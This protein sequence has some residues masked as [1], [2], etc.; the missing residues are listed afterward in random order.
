[1]KTISKLLIPLGISILFTFLFYEQSPGVNTLIFTLVSMFTIHLL[2]PSVSIRRKLVA[3]VAPLY[4]S[5][6]LCL[7]VQDFTFLLWLGSYTI[8]WLL[9]AI[10]MDLITAPFYSLSSIVTAPFKLLATLFQ[11]LNTNPGIK[12]GNFII[13][14]LIG[15]VFFL[16]Y[17]SSNLLLSDYLANLRFT[18]NRPELLICIIFA[19]L[20]HLGLVFVQYNKYFNEFQKIPD[21]IEGPIENS[22]NTN[23]Y[24]QALYSFGLASLFLTVLN[25]TDI[26]VLSTGKLPE[27]ITYSQYVHSGF[28]SLL[29][30]MILA[31]I[32]VLYFLKGQLNYHINSKQLRI[33]VFI[34]ISQ[35][36]ILCLTT[37][38][39]NSMYVSTYG[40]T[41]QRITVYMFLIIVSLA[42]CLLIHKV[43]SAHST[44]AFMKKFVKYAY[45]IIILAF[46]IPFDIVITH[47]NL[48]IAKEKDMSYVI[49]RKGADFK[50]IRTFIDYNAKDFGQ[51]KETID[52]KIKRKRIMANRHGWQSWNL[53]LSSYKE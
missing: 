24:K 39:K 25:V 7:Y 13:P 31:I 45:L 50:K 34:W 15:V 40:L 41:Y 8:M 44:W 42:L 27:G 46:T 38:V 43:N 51:W 35:N 20:W 12:L 30:A 6:L 32:M 1:M 3:F 47:Y 16:L 53:Y 29:F 4:T 11:K 5:V 10:K 26:A 17:T 18:I 52:D 14:G 2:Y 37:F 23:Q 36:F 21:H 33:A 28:N 49:H 22:S 9:V 19:F 48:D